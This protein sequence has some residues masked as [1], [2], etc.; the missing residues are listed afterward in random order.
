MYLEL[1]MLFLVSVTQAQGLESKPVVAFIPNWSP[2]FS[3]ENIRLT[4]AYTERTSAVPTYTWY[5]D[6]EEI[7]HKRLEN[8]L[9][10]KFAETTHDGQYQCTL[11]FTAGLSD[12][13]RLHVINGQLGQVILQAPPYIHE[14]DDLKL[15]CHHYY[16]YSANL[17]IFYKDDTVIRD[18]GP[19]AVLSFENV[20]HEISG[21]YKCIK[22]VLYNSQYN[23]HIGEASISVKELFTVPEVSVSPFPVLEGDALTLHCTTSHGLSG[24]FKYLLY[25]FY[26]DRK[27]IRQFND[28]DH[29]Y[30]QADQLEDFKNISCE[31]KG[32]RVRK[33]SK[34][35][36]IEINKD[37]TE[38][39][40][41][42]ELPLMIEGDKM[43]LTC[44]TRS[45][46]GTEQDLQFA[47]FKDVQ[48]VQNLSLSK[49][50]TVSHAEVKD[51][52]NYF[53]EV[54]MSTRNLTK[55][56]KKFYVPIRGQNSEQKNLA[57]ELIMMRHVLSGCILIFTILFIF[58]HIK[59]I[60]SLEVVNEYSTAL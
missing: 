36:N 16:G 19:E 18:W 40:I 28:F 5:K 30:G 21:R 9:L 26:N 34:V 15:R 49:Q 42:P 38:P 35:L 22:E 57:Y 56:S 25:A 1:F 59:F 46:P 32:G 52:G 7:Q 43:T 55:R 3:G 54:E 24:Q 6:G 8:S 27:E 39:V 31:V 10:I 41:K 4:C 11:G 58:Y 53:C 47:F 12:P 29:Y 23:Q 51:S 2:I 45:I 14:G 60:K 48:N 50:Y 37:F 44:N 17:T 20:S 13:V 33:R